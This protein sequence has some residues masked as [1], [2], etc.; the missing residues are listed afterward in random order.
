MVVMTLRITAT[1][2][3]VS[4]VVPAIFSVTSLF[5]VVVVPTSAVVGSRSAGIA[6][7]TVAAHGSDVA[8]HC[9]PHSE[10]ADCIR[11]LSLLALVVLFFVL[12]GPY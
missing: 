12:V 3:V 11:L 2:S 4:V 9:S 1:W 8:G 10:V 7:K 6:C 5:A